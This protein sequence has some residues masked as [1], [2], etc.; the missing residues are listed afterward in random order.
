MVGESGGQSIDREPDVT[1]RDGC[2]DGH[3]HKRYLDNYDEAEKYE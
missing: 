2:S 3:V 1:G